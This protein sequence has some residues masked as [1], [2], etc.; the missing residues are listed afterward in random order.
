MSYDIET[1]EEGGEAIK[2]YRFL[3]G[4][5][6]YLFNDSAEA[7]VHTATGDT[8][9][10]LTITH[11]ELTHT[12]EKN[13]SKVT[14]EIAYNDRF[15]SDL[16]DWTNDS[17]NMINVSQVHLSDA[18]ETI[19]LMWSGRLLERKRINLKY[20]LTAEPLTTTLDRSGLRAKYT[21]VCRHTLY[22]EGC[23]VNRDTHKVDSVV[24][25]V[26][27]NILRVNGISS[28]PSGY[29]TGGFIQIKGSKIGRYIVAHAGDTLTVSSAF[30]DLSN[31]D[32][33]E[34]YPGC[35]HVRN[36]CK[37]KFNNILN[38]GG[39]PYIPPKNPFGG[40]SIV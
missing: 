33:V 25:S 35:D 28:R 2:L 14:F 1:S 24:K 21:R 31:G 11:S 10:S 29:F 27:V 8:Y 6:T 23:N 20:Q 34:I 9:E 37:S 5:R 38:Y 36:T 30:N 12:S 39:F 15:V 26:A 3:I 16:T 7:W 19:V 13:K 18:S 40:S 22:K 32:L 4:G 17:V